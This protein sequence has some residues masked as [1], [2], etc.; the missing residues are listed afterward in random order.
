MIHITQAEKDEF[1]ADRRQR[2][3]LLVELRTMHVL[4][5][6]SVSDL[7]DGGAMEHLHRMGEALLHRAQKLGYHLT[8]ER[9]AGNPLSMAN[10]DYAVSI[11]PDQRAKVKP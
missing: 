9:K 2:D 11:W 10:I 8:I 4:M 7:I 1:E 5:G 3:L 6:N